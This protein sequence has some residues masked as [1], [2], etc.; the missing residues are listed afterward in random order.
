MDSLLEITLDEYYYTVTN[1]E[2]QITDIED[3][4]GFPF[5]TEVKHRFGDQL[6]W[7]S[8]VS[9]KQEKPIN[10]TCTAAQRQQ[11]LSCLPYMR[12]QF[13]Q[14]TKFDQTLIKRQLISMTEV[15]S[16]VGGL[17]TT[18]MLFVTFIYKQVFRRVR[19]FA[20]MSLAKKVF[21]VKVPSRGCCKR[22]DRDPEIAKQEIRE[23]QE[24]RASMKMVD[25]C[26]DV[27]TLVREICLLKMLLSFAI[28]KQ[29]QEL[30]P[31]NLCQLKLL[32]LKKKRK[33]S[34]DIDYLADSQKQE[35]KMEGLQTPFVDSND[36]W[37]NGNEK[38]SMPYQSTEKIAQETL[39]IENKDE[40]QKFDTEPKEPTDFR[41]MMQNAVY[42]FQA[43]I[44]RDIR[45]RAE[46][47]AIKS[48]SHLSGLTRNLQVSDIKSDIGK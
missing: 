41:F 21:D 35:Q 1:P 23:I 10:L 8:Y 30:I 37:E 20:K 40:N 2:F 42:Q 19:N 31:K 43:S 39:F 32:E 27:Y 46:S 45:E 36:D 24:L 44:S 25:E 33:V 4:R 12:T 15:F 26:L 17:Y 7:E 11:I 29:T 6:N 14:Q 34:H 48:T 3:E 18:I 16:K 5:T 38:G 47:E 13:E 9:V 22:K 28:D